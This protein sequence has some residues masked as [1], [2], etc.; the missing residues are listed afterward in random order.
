MAINPARKT[1]LKE[2]AA[3]AGV[4][5][6]TASLILNDKTD[7]FPAST[8]DRVRESAARLGYR[9]NALARSLRS[10]RTHTIGLISDEIATTP[11]AGAMIRGAQEAAWKAGHVLMHID[12]EGDYEMEQAALEAML[13]RKVDGLVYARMHHQ[14]VD[15]PDVLTEVPAVLLDARE[16]TETLASVVPDERSGAKG[17]VEHL[18][19]MG[20]TR[21]GFVQCVD[22]IPAAYQ[23]LEGFQTALEEAG[24]D[25][26]ERWTVIDPLEPGGHALEVDRLLT[27]SDR[28]TALF[29]FND[30]MALGAYNS[31]RRLGLRIPEDLS[32]VGFDNLETVAPWLDPGL[33]TVEL[34]HYEMGR[35][36]VDYLERLIGGESLAPEQHLMECPLIERNS[37][38][39]RQT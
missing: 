9:P 32:V 6:A 37:V 4:S 2:V 16:P 35:W 17:A 26:N 11:F 23:R 19:A 34:P 28:P 10:Q 3:D 39:R 24:L 20:H 8:I 15:I 33:T 1:R 5:S 36:A 38:S 21:I 31:A 25:Y 27:G 14:V 22:P 13:E 7:A 29:C 12:T 18:I 30:R